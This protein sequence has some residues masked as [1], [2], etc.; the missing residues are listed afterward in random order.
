MDDDRLWEVQDRAAR[1]PD[2]CEHRG[3][4]ARQQA[5]STASEVRVEP[6]GGHEGVAAHRHV[7]AV[8]AVRRRK[9]PPLGAVVECAPPVLEPGGHPCGPPVDEVE[10]DGPAGGLN[11]RIL[12]RPQV[13]V[14]PPWGRQSVV[15]EEEHHV[16][17]SVRDAQVACTGEPGDRLRHRYAPRTCAAPRPQEG[18]RSV[19]RTVVDH[20]D[21]HRVALLIETGETC[22]EQMPP[23]ARADNDGPRL[24]PCTVEDERGSVAAVRS[25]FGRIA[26]RLEPTDENMQGVARRL[27]R[28]SSATRRPQADGRS[29]A[30]LHEHPHVE[31]EAHMSFT[32]PGAPVSSAASAT[33]RRSRPARSSPQATTSNSCKVP[34][35]GGHRR[36]IR[37]ALSPRRA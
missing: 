16:P 6:A 20:D 9:R 36:V 11:R 33:R 1:R 26:I 28:A 15:V 25:S 37:A 31:C 27:H 21:R 24:H 13:G 22:L 7:G 30:S 34:A 5:S 10:Q 23:V 29:E 35:P 12:V 18:G 32:G 3:L 4:L 2:L 17:G 14:D 19:G 8:R